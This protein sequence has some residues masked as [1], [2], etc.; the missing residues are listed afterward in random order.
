METYSHGHGR[1]GVMVEVNCETDFVAKIGGVPHL[2][3]RTGAA[4]GRRRPEYMRRGWCPPKWWRAEKTIARIPG[5]RRRQA[6]ECA[7]Q[8]IVEGRLEKFYD[9]ICLLAQ[10]YVHDES[11]TIEMLLKQTIGP[12]S[13]RTSSSGALCAGKCGESLLKLEPDRRLPPNR[14]A[15]FFIRLPARSPGPQ[16]KKCRTMTKYRR[17]LLKLGGE[18]L[19]VREGSGIDPTLA[20]R[21]LPESQ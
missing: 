19:S 13:V 12:R 17:I 8:R 1:V 15:S 5:P 6:P 10:P 20:E 7:G 2:C 3:A 21:S 9:E 14:L 4:D 16:T 18:A 11:V